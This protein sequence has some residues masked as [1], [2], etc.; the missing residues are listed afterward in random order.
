MHR[1]REKTNVTVIKKRNIAVL[2]HVIMCTKGTQGD[3]LSESVDL[4]T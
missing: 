1:D 2:L 4:L 3:Y